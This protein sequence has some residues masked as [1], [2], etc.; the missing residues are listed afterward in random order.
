M[1]SKSTLG[2]AY[3]TVFSCAFSGY[4]WVYSHSSTADIPSLLSKFYAD[5]SLLREKHGPILRV[6]RDN[7]S[8]NVSQKVTAFLDQHSICSKTSN[9]YEPR[10]TG[11]AE[12]MIQTLCSAARTVLVASGLNGRFWSLALQ[13]ASRVHN[14]QY[15]PLLDS[16]PYNVVHGTKPDVSRDQAFGVEAWIYLRS[17]QRKDP[18]F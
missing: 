1:Q 2:H 18:K 7:A 15:S 13:F 10:Q 4:V 8:V 6:R 14:L 5:S 3:A 16:S 12:R 11:K 17:E 9:P